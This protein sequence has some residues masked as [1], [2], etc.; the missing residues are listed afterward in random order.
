MR[1]TVT[2]SSS[3]GAGGAIV[4]P[5][6]ADALGLEFFDRAVTVAAAREL[7]LDLSDALALDSKVPGRF[8]RILSALANVALPIGLPDFPSDPMTN[9]S[10]LREATEEVLRK[11]ADGSG[12]V[13]LGRA[14]MVVLGGRPDVLSVRLSGPVEARIAHAIAHGAMDEETARAQQRSTDDARDAYGM[15][16]YGVRQS[17]PKLYHLVIDSTALSFDACT[18]IVVAAAKDRFGSS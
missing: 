8:D 9:P 5:A 17:D 16:F 11:I 6:V 4:G 2:I 12:G 15:A 3:F 10:R 1:G 13:I 7:D 18:E 14:S